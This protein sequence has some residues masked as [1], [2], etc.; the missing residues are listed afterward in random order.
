MP[1]KETDPAGHLHGV[2][3]RAA[4]N[5]THAAE[6][7]EV[8]ANLHEQHAAEMAQRGWLASKE[9]AERLALAERELVDKERALAD[10][11]LAKAAAE[12]GE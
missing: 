5:H 10:D 6:L 1:S 7:H 3:R 11:E 12:V 4:L 8:A 2:H 9:R